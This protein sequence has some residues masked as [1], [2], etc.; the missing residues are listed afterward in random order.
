MVVDLHIEGV[1]SLSA[2]K[3]NEMSNVILIRK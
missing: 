3:V 2:P 1:N